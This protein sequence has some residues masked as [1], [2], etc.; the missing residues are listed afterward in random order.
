MTVC[1]GLTGGIASGKSTV[2][3]ILEELGADFINA[4]L[5]GHQIYLPGR[6]AWK[7]I[8]DTWGQELLL[9]DRT[10][11]RQKLG[12][13]VFSDPK[14]LAKLNEITHPRI[15]IEL[16]KEMVAKQKIGGDKKALVVEAA[17]LIEAKWFPLFEQI[18]VVVTEKETAIQRLADSKGL[19]RE[20][21]QAR[22]NAQLSN[23]E[24]ISY[25][26]VVI[27]NNGTLEEMRKQ[28]EQ[29]WEKL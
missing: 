5:V 4:D 22:I 28:V 23:E 3:G 20:Q 15:Y 12:A 11:D 26:N 10:I 8:I 13:I 7:E 17:I 18:W 21:A 2:S 27:E 24:R 19:T 14:A 25:A 6:D 1:I 9:L 29:A 16:E